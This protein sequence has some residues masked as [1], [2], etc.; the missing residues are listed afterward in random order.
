MGDVAVNEHDDER[1]RT[2]R[3]IGRSSSFMNHFRAWYEGVGR[4]DGTL[5]TF[6]KY[7]IYVHASESNS[8]GY[9][10]STLSELQQSG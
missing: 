7:K 1:T 8:G 10:S 9:T 5:F 3:I 6:A 2:W 4:L